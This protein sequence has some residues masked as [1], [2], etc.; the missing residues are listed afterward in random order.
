MLGEETMKRLGDASGP[1]IL[2]VD[3][4]YK[5][6][7]CLCGQCFADEHA[8]GQRH[9]VLLEDGRLLAVPPSWIVSLPDPPGWEAEREV[10]NRV[11]ATLRKAAFKA[12]FTGTISP[13]WLQDPVPFAFACWAR[14]MAERGSIHAA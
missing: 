2:F 8:M 3:E 7:R 9:M 1:R 6:P 12:S 11:V 13:L 14:A 10:L 5:A 4:N